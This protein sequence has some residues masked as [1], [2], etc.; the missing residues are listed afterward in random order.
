MHNSNLAGLSLRVHLAASRPTE[1]VLT[2]GTLPDF[3]QRVAFES[4]A[5]RPDARGVGSHSLVNFYVRAQNELNFLS[6]LIITSYGLQWN[7]RTTDAWP[8]S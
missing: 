7:N 2:Q 6:H 5:S 8:K 4:R 3:H 1:S